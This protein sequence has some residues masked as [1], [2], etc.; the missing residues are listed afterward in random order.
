MHASQGPEPLSGILADWVTIGK[1]FPGAEIVPVTWEEWVDKLQTVAHLLPSIT[2]E[3]GETWIHGAPSDPHKQVRARARGGG[4]A[5][6]WAGSRF[7]L[8][9]IATHLRVCIVCAALPAGVVQE[10]PASAHGVP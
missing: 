5:A 4:Q 10:P 1:T 9:V 7:A 6:W 2:T 3:I 8:A